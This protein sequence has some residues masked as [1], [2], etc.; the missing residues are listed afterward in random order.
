LVSLSDPKV[1]LLDEPFAG[2]TREDVRRLSDVIREFAASGVAVC[3]VEHDME[4]VLQLCDRVEVLDAGRVIFSGTPEA[5]RKDHEVR[6]VYLGD[7]AAASRTGP[8]ASTG[9]DGAPD[10]QSVKGSA[11]LSIASLRSGYAK[12]V[13]V[14]RG[15]DVEVMKGEIV[16]V[17]GPNGAGKT[18]LLK[19]VSGLIRARAGDVFVDGVEVTRLP[20]QSVV[21][22]GITYVPEGREV[23]ASLTVNENIWLGGFS[24]PEGRAEM[25]Q[26]VL[27]LFPRLA[28]RLSQRAG[29]LSG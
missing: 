2:V 19:T 18:T 6:R 3:V 13:D 1:L 12:R 23:F 29:S 28:D 16:A 8:R 26:T 5:V 9:T 27:D 20:M 22:S 15:I 11:L 17:V 24:H 21:R 10:P 14:L 25:R 7:A 4:A